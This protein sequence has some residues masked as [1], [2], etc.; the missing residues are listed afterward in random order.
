MKNY[1]TVDGGTTN[2]RVYLVKNGIIVD[3]EYIEL[4]AGSQNREKKAL[5]IAIKNAIRVIQA[6]N[7]LTEIE[8]EKILASGM[9][10]SEFGL[11]E[12]SHV[13]TPA[14]ISTLHAGM[15][16]TI[17]SDISTI[18]FVFLPGVKTSGADISTADMMRGEETELYGL[19]DTHRRDAVY[20]LPGSHCKIIKTDNEGRIKD[21]QTTLTGEM[22]AAL[23]Q[24]TILRDAVDLNVQ[25]LDTNGLLAGYKL[26]KKTDINQALFKVR[27]L[28]NKFG[29]SKEYVYSFFMG[30]ILHA[31]IES[32]CKTNAQCIVIGGK[33]QIR[34]A[35][36]ILLQQTS[37]AEIVALDEETVNNAT[38]HGA[39]KIYEC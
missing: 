15:K 1:I 30:V 38:A 14:G 36:Q 13:S 5:E 31:E 34:E 19:T 27:V 26:C 39:V 29:K 8:I 4:G 7:G 17:L 9:I 16:E 25:Q 24:N 20:V 22:I 35:L 11:F 32:L 37:S 12:L 33:K 3:T 2:T 21:F 18:P 28:K 6:R 10:T 23:S